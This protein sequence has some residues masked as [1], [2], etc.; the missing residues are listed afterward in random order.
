MEQVCGCIVKNGI[1][2]GGES[3]GGSRGFSNLPRV[4]LAPPDRL[5]S[6]C[7]NA[8]VSTLM[9]HINYVAVPMRLFFSGNASPLSAGQQQLIHASLITLI[10]SAYFLPNCYIFSWTVARWIEKCVRLEV[11]K[12]GFASR[13]AEKRGGLESWIRAPHRFYFRLPWD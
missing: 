9:N 13:S 2:V 6:T 8:E 10:F 4:G 1:K 5:S 3:T 11:F 12:T 7:P